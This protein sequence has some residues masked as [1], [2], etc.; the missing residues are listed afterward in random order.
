MLLLFVMDYG[1][2]LFYLTNL[3]GNDD[4]TVLI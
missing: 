2:T 3:I 4:S 1:L